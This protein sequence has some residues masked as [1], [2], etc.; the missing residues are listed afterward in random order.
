MGE[1][2]YDVFISYRWDGGYDTAKHLR[3]LLVQDGYSVCF[4]TETVYLQRWVLKM[5]TSVC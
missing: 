5:S 4:D 3:D 2:I 1:K